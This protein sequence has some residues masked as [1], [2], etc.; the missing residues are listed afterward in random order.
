M[1]AVEVNEYSLIWAPDYMHQ[2]QELLLVAVKSYGRALCYTSDELQNDRQW[3]AIA[4]RHASE[5]LWNDREIAL[6]AIQQSERSIYLQE[7]FAVLS[8]ELKNDRD[9]MLAAFK[10][11]KMIGNSC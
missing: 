1:K 4:L 5:E 10:Y 3:K 8:S 2:D 6:V 11:K 9:F 7:V